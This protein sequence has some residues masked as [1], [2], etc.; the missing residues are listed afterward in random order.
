[1]KHLKEIYSQGTHPVISSFPKRIH[2]F[3][4]PGDEIVNHL[5]DKDASDHVLGSGVFG[6]VIAHKDHVYKLYKDRAYHG[7]VKHVQKNKGNPNLPV[8][9]AAGK[10]KGT[11]IKAVKME[12]LKPLEEN[13]PIHKYL[14]D[15]GKWGMHTPQFNASN[16]KQLEHELN[17]T[18]HGKALKEAYP[19]FHRTLSDIA[20][21]FPK[22][23]ADLHKGNFMVRPDGTHGGHGT[24]VITDPLAS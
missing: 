11:Q 15:L 17:N 6:A 2:S 21:K 4:D 8:I 16:G 18:S 10:I 3:R 24:P 20:H 14:F 1:M 23:W 13:H 12:R 7:F 9:H 5:Y 22:G 19:N